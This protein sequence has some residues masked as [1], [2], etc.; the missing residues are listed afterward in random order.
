[1]RRLNSKKSAAI[2]LVEAAYS[3]P[4]DESAW[5][6]VVLQAALPVV[7]DAVF[8]SGMIYSRPPGARGARVQSWKHVG[9]SD[10]MERAARAYAN[11]VPTDRPITVMTGIIAFRRACS[12][13][14]RDGGS[15][16]ARAVR[17]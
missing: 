10:H 16:F 3:L 14:T 12:P 8:A 2:A 15:P 11:K 1:M 4:A 9:A 17:T 5:L 6:E 13:I 7:G